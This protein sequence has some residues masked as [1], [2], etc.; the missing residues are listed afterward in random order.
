MAIE[1][2]VSRFKLGE[3]P[4]NSSFGRNS[5]LLNGFPHSNQFAGN[6]TPPGMALNQDF[7]EFLELLNKHEVK[8]LVVGGYSVAI[9][10]HPRYT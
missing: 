9:H 7:K 2:V 6:I 8:Y 3:E 10:G 1:R 4:R 5:Q